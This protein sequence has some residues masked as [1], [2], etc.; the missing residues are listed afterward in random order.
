M[1]SSQGQQEH[2]DCCCVTHT[3]GLRRTQ[4]ACLSQP[5]R[6]FDAAGPP[7]CYP[8]HR[9]IWTSSCAACARSSAATR[10]SPCCQ[11]RRASAPPLW[12]PRPSCMQAC[13]CPLARAAWTP[14]VKAQWRPPRRRRP[15]RRA[16]LKSA[17][18]ATRAPAVSMR[19]AA[20]VVAGAAATRGAAAAAMQAAEAVIATAVPASWKLLHSPQQPRR[21]LLPRTSCFDS[22][23]RRPQRRRRGGSAGHA[24]PAFCVPAGT[25]WGS[26]TA[27]GRCRLCPG[28][29]AAPRGAAARHP[30]GSAGSCSKRQQLLWRAAPS[31]LSRLRRC[32]HGPGP[33]SDP[34]AALPFMAGAIGSVL[35]I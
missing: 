21:C 24:S 15:P 23:A 25:G 12:R 32:P 14:T 18:A 5:S 6:S 13:T 35:L 8:P 30:C 26:S 2:I 27:T 11:T 3:P 34:T 19:A 7:P 31:C 28:P 17:A 1:H 29:P 33:R 20:V 9:P 10:T 4:L 16:T 22:T